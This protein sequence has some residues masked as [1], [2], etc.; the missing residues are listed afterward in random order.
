MTPPPALPPPPLIPDVENMV[1]TATAVNVG[2]GAGSLVLLVPL[3]I[4]CA[5]LC[6]RRRRENRITLES[7]V[8]PRPPTTTTRGEHRSANR[9][10]LAPAERESLEALERDRVL[11]L[12]KLPLFVWSG[13]STGDECVLCIEPFT[14]G[15]TL[16]QLPCEHFYHKEVCEFHR[17]TPLRSLFPLLT[18]YAAILPSARSQ[19]I[20][21][22]LIYSMIGARRACPLCKADPI[23]H[24]CKRKTIVAPDD[25]QSH[26]AAGT[27]SRA[28]ELH[29]SP[30]S[31]LQQP[32]S[33]MQEALPNS[34][35]RRRQQQ[36]Q[37]EEEDGPQPLSTRTPRRSNAPAAGPQLIPSP[38]T[39]DNDSRSSSTS[40]AERGAERP[41]EPRLSQPADGSVEVPR[42]ALPT[43]TSPNP[44]ETPIRSDGGSAGRSSMRSIFGSPSHRQPT[45]P[46]SSQRTLAAGISATVWDAVSDVAHRIGY[47]ASRVAVGGTSGSQDGLASSARRMR[48]MVVP[49]PQSLDDNS[50]PNVPPSGRYTSSGR[51]YING[52]GSRMASGSAEHAPTQNTVAGSHAAAAEDRIR[53]GAHTTAWPEP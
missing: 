51:I 37:H 53:N 28:R 52:E 32:W 20:D 1:P 8:L 10:A 27:P 39:D 4:M 22:W 46:S 45:T 19:C 50:P 21:T 29:W 25:S 47:T 13:G 9:Q 6:L 30:R 5:I 3:T 26:P 40:S 35:Q 31:Q 36:Q 41:S 18:R 48:A 14:N 43:A 7:S 15:A 16:R 11:A 2:L 34:H 24:V 38:G 42:L 49:L 17:C 12:R 44:L 33:E 23:P